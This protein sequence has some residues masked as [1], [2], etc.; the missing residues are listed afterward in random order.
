MLTAEEM[1]NIEKIFKNKKWK[2]KDLFERYCKMLGQ[3]EA[4]EKKLILELT[5]FFLWVTFEDYLIDLKE[6]LSKFLIEEREVLKNIKR[7]VVCPLLPFDK[8]KIET[9]SSNVLCYLFE[10]CEMQGLPLLKGKT[11]EIFENFY[12][13]KTIKKDGE[14]LEE[15][16]KRSLTKIKNYDENKDIILLVDDFIGSGQTAKNSLK[17]YRETLGIDVENIRILSLA[18]HNISKEKID[19]GIKIYS[20]YF[21]DKGISNKRNTAEEIEEKIKLMRKIEKKMK[22]SSSNYKLGYKQTE[23][24]IR[25]I[26][27]PNNTFPV[28]YRDKNKNKAIFPRYK[29]S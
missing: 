25:L 5:S 11:L 24:L 3:F 26:K 14:Y 19:S 22:V 15:N 10:S 28:F 1:L 17:F 2:D 16:Y 23:A 29:G 27:T 8:L 20:K 4:N 12:I 7:I 21:I 6:I 13:W 18:V 9:K